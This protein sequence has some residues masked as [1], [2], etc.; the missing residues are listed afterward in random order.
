[1]AT[2]V[3]GIGEAQIR[4]DSHVA[5]GRGHPQRRLDIRAIDHLARVGTFLP[6]IFRRLGAR[7]ELA[8]PRRNLGQPAAALAANRRNRTADRSLLLVVG[9]GHVQ[10]LA[11]A[12]RTAWDMTA[13]LARTFAAGSHLS[14]RAWEISST[15]ADPTTVAS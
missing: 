10:P 12:V 1:M 9:Q 14:A 11:R 3:E 5:A 13:T 8:H 4:S 15:R 2:T 6:Q 7:D